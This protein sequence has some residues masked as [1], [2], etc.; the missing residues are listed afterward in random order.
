[1]FRRSRRR[2]PAN[3][4]I[5]NCS[6]D[7]GSR[8]SPQLGCRCQKQPCTKMTFLSFG[9]TRSG[10]PGRSETW[11]CGLYPNERAIFLTSSSGFVFLLRMSAIRSLRSFRVSVSIAVLFALTLRMVSHGARGYTTSSGQRFT[12]V[13]KLEH[14]C[15]IHGNGIIRFFI[16]TAFA[17]CS[18]RRV[19]HT[20]VFEKCG[21]TWRVGLTSRV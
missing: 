20:S 21:T 13:G 14:C 2:F 9:K 3:L 17:S 19:P 7:F 4:G 16:A 15:G 18:R 1:M 11:R 12:N 8:A 5:Q 6:F 10:F